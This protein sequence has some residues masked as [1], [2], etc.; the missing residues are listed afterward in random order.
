MLGFITSFIEIILHLDQH[1]STLLQEYGLWIYLLV[2]LIIFCETGLVF[3]PFLPGDSLMFAIGAL[4]SQSTLNVLILYLLLVLAAV[5]GDTV[6]Y[7]LGAY[8]GPKVFHEKVRFLKKEYLLKTEKFYEAH[9]SKTIILARFI[10]VIR[11]FAPF[12]AGI[13]KMRYSK[14][15]FYNFLGGILWVTLFLMGGYYFG[16]IPY[17]KENFSIAII[18]I[19]ILSFI[20]LLVEIIRHRKTKAQ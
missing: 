11:T 5:L 18:I 3:T 10:P 19:I 12:V 1:L 13:G 4:A 17:I 7:W 9:G 15:L 16:N 2:F 14:F 20:P 6:N 8:F